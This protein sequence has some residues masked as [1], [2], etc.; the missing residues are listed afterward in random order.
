[1]LGGLFHHLESLFDILAPAFELRRLFEFFSEAIEDDPGFHEEV[2]HFMQF[3]L[4]FFVHKILPIVHTLFMSQKIVIAEDR[5]EIREV[6]V[7]AFKDL[8]FEV[9]PVSTGRAAFEL[10]QKH[11]IDL[12][13]SDVRM[14]E[15]TGIELL[16]KLRRLKKDAIEIPPIIM[17]SALL[18]RGESYLKALGAIAVFPKPFDIR[19][20]VQTALRVLEL[21]K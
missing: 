11:S 8:G 5:V 16:R 17:T 21:S 19:E 6:L 14:P 12:I 20:V 15:G 2:G 3:T 13:I 9:F 10:V 4:F 18:G 1:M 7:K